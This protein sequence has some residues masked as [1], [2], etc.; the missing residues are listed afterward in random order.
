MY[1]MYTI[2][3]TKIARKA[4]LKLPNKARLSIDAKLEALSQAPF[5]KHHD[6]KHLIGLKNCYR[7][8]VG[9]WRIVYRLQ[10]DILM[11]E[12]IKIAH[13]REVYR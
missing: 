10:T 5:A 4:Y 13:R 12:I 11:I 7:L 2:E 3:L 1:I 8:R 6:V 9:E